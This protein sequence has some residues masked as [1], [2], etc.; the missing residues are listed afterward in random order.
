MLDM[1]SHMQKNSPRLA[2]IISIAWMSSCGFLL[3]LGAAAAYHLLVAG[4]GETTMFATT[5][6][7]GRLLQFLTSVLALHWF[8][9]GL[10]NLAGKR[11]PN[12]VDDKSEA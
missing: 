9:Y 8:I 7:L 10:L 4:F 1:M 5:T 3:I 11:Q 2:Q 6:K 12:K